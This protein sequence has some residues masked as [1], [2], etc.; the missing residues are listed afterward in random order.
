MPIS[1][2]NFLGG[3]MKKTLSLFVAL[4]AITGA[5]YALPSCTNT[6]ATVVSNGG[7]TID[8]VNFT[9]FTPTFGASS[10]TNLTSADVNVTALSGANMVGLL[11]TP[12]ATSGK[13]TAATNGSVNFAKN[14]IKIVYEFNWA[15]GGSNPYNLV[16]YKLN[17]VSFTSGNDPNN[18]NNV[19]SGKNIFDWD[20]GG[21][22]GQLSSFP[23]SKFDPNSGSFT[24]PGAPGSMSIGARTYFGVSDSATLWAFTNS[25]ASATNITGFANEF[26]YIPQGDGQVPE[27]MSLVLLG[28]GL[29]AFGLLRRKSA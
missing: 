5:A 7:C 17:G 27:P 9:N 12:T 8:S 25:T 14:D 28:S 29:L 4:L 2:F 23:I 13:F 21:T 3:T 15:G 16:Q 6:L 18:T 24:N 20:L 26:S 11:F 22:T 1:N 10:Q 19:N